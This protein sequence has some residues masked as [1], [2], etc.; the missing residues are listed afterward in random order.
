MRW[1]LGGRD[2][3]SAGV[4]TIEQ[5]LAYWR[6]AKA[7]GLDSIEQLEGEGGEEFGERLLNRVI[8]TEQVLPLLGCMLVPEGTPDGGWTPELSREVQ[9]H[10]KGL[11]A[12]EDKA[13][14][15]AIVLS[16]L[17]DFFE[18]GM[19][20]SRI[21]RTSSNEHHPG[22]IQPPRI[23]GGSGVVSSATSLEGISK[24]LRGWF[25]GLFGRSSRASA[26]AS[27]SR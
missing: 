16:T 27:G 19:G 21:S 20:S 14:F 1:T 12:P 22:P 11:T 23:D 7:S 25:A 24:R 8:A 9:A 6:V 2:F 4:S 17:I 13:R 15:R 10:L 18:S 5:D 26:F 3:E